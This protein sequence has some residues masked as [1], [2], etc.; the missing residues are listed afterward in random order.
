MRVGAY[1]FTGPARWQLR[2]KASFRR[3]LGRNGKGDRRAAAATTI[4]ASECQPTCRLQAP[5]C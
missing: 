1:R 2:E 3:A 4:S 5:H